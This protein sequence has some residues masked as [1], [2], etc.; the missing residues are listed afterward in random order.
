[1][2]QQRMLL[3]ALLAASC[4]ARAPYAAEG[5][6]DPVRFEIRKFTL[7]GNTVLPPDEA[8][9]MLAPHRGPD[10]DFADIQRA[11]EAL[12]SAYRALGY[13]V[14]Q[15]TLP[16][17]NIT[18]GEIRFVII[19]PRLGKVSVEGNKFFDEANIRASVPAL[20]EGEPPNSRA[21]ARSLAIANENPAKNTQVLLRATE[22]D[23]RVDARIRVADEKFWKV[24][25][26]GQHLGAQSHQQRE[27]DSCGRHARR[28]AA[29]VLELGAHAE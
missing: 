15:V 20:R 18:Q 5:V 1:M 11:L 6:P 2:K 28:H 25:L 17:Q 12:E 29:V 22:A 13:G 14:V 16:E 23:D 24:G 21:I 8:E 9:R 7:E 10:K 26:D 27:H 3:A 19:E 4:V